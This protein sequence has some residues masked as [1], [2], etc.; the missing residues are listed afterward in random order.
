MDM[1][2]AALLR[3]ALA[4]L[5][6]TAAFH[7]ARDFSAFRASLADYRLVSEPLLLPVAM[8][9]LLGEGAAAIAVMVPAIASVGLAA[10]AGLFALYAGAIAVNLL[11]GRHHIDCGCFGPA[12][13]R[14]IH[15]GLVVRNLLLASAAAVA[16]ALP[17][18]VRPVHWV[19]GLTLAGGI[20]ALTVLY[21]AADQLLAE[22]PR[23]R[24]LRSDA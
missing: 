11:R 21:H 12:A 10:G 13:R 19:D 5:L 3:T 18:V 22:A 1:I 7:K 8:T 17:A 6:A 23:F 2:L 15:P 16:A 9:L 14:P 4:A 24:L 20:A